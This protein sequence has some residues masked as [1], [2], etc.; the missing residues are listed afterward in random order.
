[1]PNEIFINEIQLKLCKNNFAV[2]LA[3][4]WQRPLQQLSAIAH[5]ESVPNKSLCG[6]INA[7]CTT[8]WTM[9]KSSCHITNM[10]QSTVTT[11]A[12]TTATSTSTPTAAA[13]LAGFLLSFLFPP[14]RQTDR[15]II[16][17]H[18]G[19]FNF[20]FATFSRHFKQAKQT[21][22]RERGAKA[23]HDT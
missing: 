10:P 5:L 22:C 14:P 2:C 20:L 9:H 18:I 3:Q 13:A 4:I 8:L 17:F 6:T 12:T 7:N 1:M 21:K 11:N 19:F 16:Q 23:T 15:D